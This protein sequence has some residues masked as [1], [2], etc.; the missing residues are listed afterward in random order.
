MEDFKFNAINQKILDCGH[1]PSEHS[2]I[3]TGYGTDANGK[4]HCYSCIATIDRAQMDKDGR[5]TLY[6]VNRDGKYFV[7]NWPASLS[8]PVQSFRTSWHNIAGKDGR[9]DF[10]FTDH[11]G[12]H[13]HGYQIGAY[14]EIAHCRRVK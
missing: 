9:I 13:W 12:K 4:K 8:Y 6:L 14:N 1:V 3:T 2:E 11:A 5:A 10:W 7:T